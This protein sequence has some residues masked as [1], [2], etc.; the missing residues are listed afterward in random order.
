MSIAKEVNKL[1]DQML[2]IKGE[3]A[4]MRADLDANATLVNN[5]TGEKISANKIEELANNE[6][7]AIKNELNKVTN[8]GKRANGMFNNQ[9]YIND[10]LQDKLL[11]ENGGIT[12][13]PAPSPSSLSADHTAFCCHWKCCLLAFLFFDRLW[14]C[15]EFGALAA[16]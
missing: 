4:R 12:E 3:I 8:E 2:T 15:L 9:Y 7:T 14:C 16:D 1:L 11:V 13:G 10:M 6:I 5:Q